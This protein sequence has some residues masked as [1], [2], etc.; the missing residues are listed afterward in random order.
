MCGFDGIIVLPGVKSCTSILDHMKEDV[1]KIQRWSLWRF[2]NFRKVQEHIAD[3]QV[4]VN[5]L[6]SMFHIYSPFFII[7]FISLF[8][9]TF[10]PVSGLRKVHKK[11]VS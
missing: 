4:K 3:F 10:R 6:V 9:L 7:S 1:M 2:A 8:S 11:Q 5:A